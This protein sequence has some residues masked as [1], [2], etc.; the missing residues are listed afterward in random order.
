M[1]VMNL[2][3][4]VANYPLVLNPRALIVVAASLAFWSLSIFWMVLGF[5]PFR[6]DVAA[7]WQDSLQ[8]QQPYDPFHLPFYPFL[9]AL[10]RALTFDLLPAIVLMQIVVFLAYLAGALLVY[11]LLRRANLGRLPAT[12]GSLLFSAWPFVGLVYAVYP[13]SDT[14]AVTLILAGL[15]CLQRSQVAVAGA[16]FGLALVTHKISWVFVALLT[17]AWLVNGRFASKRA[18]L[19]YFPPLLAPIVLL[20]LA[21]SFYY[22]SP[23]W[24]F[25]STLGQEAD[26]RSEWFLL[27][28]ILG[29]LS[30]GFSGLVK[31]AIVAGL[32]VTAGISTILCYRSKNPM[33]PYGVALAGAVFL[34]CIFLSALNIWAGVRFSRLLV[35]PLLWGLHSPESLSHRARLLWGGLLAVALISQFAYAWYTAE[36]FFA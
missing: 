29:S 3:T 21:G 23:A 7:Y 11:E 12:L 27:D 17:L 31:A 4:R 2:S 22:D 35:L 34:L 6:S 16:F 10:A 5:D 33:K 19:A 9:I 24:L 18:L 28:G 20:W 25:S 26:S 1:M 14:V 32:L 30:H 8:W 15:Y 36:V 13:V